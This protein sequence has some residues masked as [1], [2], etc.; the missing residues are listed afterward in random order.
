MP[1]LRSVSDAIDY[2]NVI[3]EVR[4][5]PGTVLTLFVGGVSV[6]EGE[7]DLFG[8]LLEGAPELGMVAFGDFDEAQAVFAAGAH[9]RN[10]LGDL[11]AP[12][13]S[14]SLSGMKRAV[15]PGCSGC[16]P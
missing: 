8:A 6:A 16:S 9:A 12:E 15:S 7:T 14:P 3:E 5:C 11:G 4:S 1:Q 2:A 13:Q 10:V